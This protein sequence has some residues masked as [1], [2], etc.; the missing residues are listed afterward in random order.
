MEAGWGWA[1]HTLL[2]NRSVLQSRGFAGLGMVRR[3]K[4][5]WTIRD[6]VTRKPAGAE[7]SAKGRGSAG[8]AVCKI[9]HIRIKM[10]P[11]S[12]EPGGA[13]KQEAQGCVSHRP[14][15]GYKWVSTPCLSVLWMGSLRAP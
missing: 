12:C 3:Q 4:H 9:L 13:G 2:S 8:A 15:A 1:G 11:L 7:D 10:W 5:T 14:K 6:R